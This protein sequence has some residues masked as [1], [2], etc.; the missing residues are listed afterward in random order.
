MHSGLLLSKLCVPATQARVLWV[1]Q[2]AAAVALVA[3]LLA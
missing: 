2:V 3:A 1:L